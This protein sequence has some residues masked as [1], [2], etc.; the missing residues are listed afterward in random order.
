MSTTPI[1]NLLGITDEDT[2]AKRS[3][4]LEVKAA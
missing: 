4:D 2:Q 3:K 1:L